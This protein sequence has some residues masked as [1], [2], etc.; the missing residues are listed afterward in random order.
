[1]GILEQHFY[2]G[3][4]SKYIRVFG[5]VFDNI[6]IKRGNNTYIEVPIAWA[7]GQKYNI[8]NEQNPD[9]DLVRF[10]QIHPRMSYEIT[11]VVRDLTRVKNKLHR[12]SATSID[13][14]V[15]QYMRVPYIFNFR[16]DMVVQYKDDIYQI[17]EQILV[18]FNPSI[19][20]IVKDNQ[21]LDGQTAITL[22]LDDQTL[23]DTFEGAFTEK[24]SITASLNFSLEGFLYMPTS[25]T[26]E[27]RTI[28]INYLDYDTEELFESDVI[29]PDE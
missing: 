24:R 17:L 19:Q 27:I 9:P 3:T 23:E 15:T 29:V 13:G 26:E 28:T 25:E 2:H 4:I 20:I 14:S 1:M 5:T 7:S 12:I 6:R 22:T 11:N 21:D 8:R 18:Y 16:L 10:R